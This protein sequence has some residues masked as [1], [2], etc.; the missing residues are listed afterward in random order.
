[1]SYTLKSHNDETNTFVIDVNGYIITLNYPTDIEVF[2]DLS[3]EALDLLAS[4][5]VAT[6]KDLPAY[7]EPESSTTPSTG[8]WF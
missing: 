2:S 8:A 5:F 7:Q 4:G 6:H 1:M 3:Q